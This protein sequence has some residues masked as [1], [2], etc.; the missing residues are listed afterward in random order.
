[1]DENGFYYSSVL[2]ITKVLA[3][4]SS[5]KSLFL[6]HDEIIDIT[7]IMNSC[8]IIYFYFTVSYEKKDIIF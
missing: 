3:F 4:P 8:F 6:V 5:V 2:S 1:M 7:E